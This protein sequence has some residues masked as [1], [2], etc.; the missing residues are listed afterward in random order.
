MA[1]FLLMILVR[2]I[3]AGGDN[4]R[5]TATVLRSYSTLGYLYEDSLFWNA[6]LANYVYLTGGIPALG[7]V[8]ERNQD[9]PLEW[10]MNTFGC[11]YRQMGVAVPRYKNFSEIPFQFNVYTAIADWY[12]DFGWPGII[13]IPLVLGLISGWLFEKARKKIISFPQLAI[14]GFIMLMLEFSIFISI[15]FQGFFWIALAWTIGL[16]Y[17]N[18]FKRLLRSVYC[19]R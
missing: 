10:G 14:L 9:A 16:G 5:G 17:G 6:S 2:Q 1:L 15:S 3:R 18:D 12:R 8:M 4:F 11:F 13:L 7:Y 19:H